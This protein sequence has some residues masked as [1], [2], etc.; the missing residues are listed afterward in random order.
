M[1]WSSSS[2]GIAAELARREHFALAAARLQAHLPADGHRDRDVDDRRFHTYWTDR[3]GSHNR[4][5]LDH[6]GDTVH[7]DLRIV[8]LE[9]ACA[10]IDVLEGRV[11][12]RRWH[13]DRATLRAA[14]PAADR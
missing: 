2:A 4:A 6:S 9:L 12:T 8:P 7:L 14:M 3:H 10:V 5:S 11:P 13:A 1:P